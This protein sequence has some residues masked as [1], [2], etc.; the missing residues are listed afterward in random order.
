MSDRIIV[1][2]EGEKAGELNREE[3]TQERVLTL[4]SGEKLAN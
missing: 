1:M 4:A 3:A 2:H